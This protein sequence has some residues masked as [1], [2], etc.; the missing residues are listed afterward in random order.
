MFAINATTPSAKLGENRGAI[1]R[2]VVERSLGYS[3]SDE[4]YV[5]SKYELYFSYSIFKA[6]T[7]PDCC[8]C[9][10]GVGV[11]ETG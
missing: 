7:V 2:R 8:T 11:T 3:L 6:T 4:L 10:A 1:L 5:T 9:R